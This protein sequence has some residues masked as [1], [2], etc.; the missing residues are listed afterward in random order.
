MPKP[1]DYQPDDEM[2]ARLSEV[3]KVADY[4]DRADKLWAELGTTPRYKTGWPI[5]DSYVGGGFGSEHR[6]ELVVLAGET[7]VGKSTLAANLALRL[8]GKLNGNP[9]LHYISLENPVEDVYNTARSVKGGADLLFL[10]DQLSFPSDTLIFGGRGWRS[11]D[12]L[13]HMEYILQAYGTKLFIL[14]HLNF[15]FENEQQ[16]EQE[17]FRIRVIMRKLSRFCMNHQA[18]VFA[19]S[20]VNRNKLPGNAM[21]ND[22][23]YGSGSI[24]QA[25]TKVLL[26]SEGD[27]L[28]VA[29]DVKVN[30]TKSR[31]TRVDRARSL[32]FDASNYRWEELGW[33]D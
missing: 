30:L 24:A 22:R 3:T 6:G 31:Y 17:S 8:M 18:C 28:D 29:R 7:A 32:R 25:A 10:G 12:L 20:H 16:A 4:K 5:F 26:L 2:K 14:D 13:F 11:E 9:S 27:A 23:I 21:T 1:K 33:S 15:M 19:I